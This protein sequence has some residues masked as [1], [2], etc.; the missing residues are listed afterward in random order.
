MFQSQS[1]LITQ[2]PQ[3]TNP[4]SHNAPLCN[5]NVHICAHFCYKMVHCGIFVQCI[6]GFVRWVSWVALLIMVLS[7]EHCSY[8]S[9]AATC[10]AG[11]SHSHSLVTHRITMAHHSYNT[12]LSSYPEYFWEPHWFSGLLEISRVTWQLCNTVHICKK[13]N[14][15][16]CDLKNW[17]HCQWLLV[18]R[19]MASFNLLY[20]AV[21]LES[22]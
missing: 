2:I 6:V 20:Y 14:S 5:K 8:T 18:V 1:R 12:Q 7:N 21:K 22:M 17:L 10:P 4:I 16:K 13:C 15:W 11:H 9:T 19:S 3:C